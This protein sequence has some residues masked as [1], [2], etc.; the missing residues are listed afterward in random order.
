MES[1]HLVHPALST[2]PMRYTVYEMTPKGLKYEVKDVPVPAEIWEL[3][4]KNFLANKWWRDADQPGYP[5]GKQEIPGFYESPW[6][7]KGDVVFK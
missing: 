3:A 6:T 4:R 2:Y 7:M 1:I 5:G